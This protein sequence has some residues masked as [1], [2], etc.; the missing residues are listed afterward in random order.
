MDRFIRFEYSDK[1]FKLIDDYKNRQVVSLDLALKPVLSSVNNLEYY[2]KKAK[3]NCHYPS[4]HNLSKDE[5]AAVY[6]YTDDCGDQSLHNV[7]NQTLQTK[8]KKKLKPWFNFLQLFNTALEKL[9][10]VK[11]TIWR[12][13]PIDTVEKLEEN[14]ELVLCCV[15][16]SSLS[17]DI[18]KYFLTNNPILCSIE[19]LNGKDIHD[20]TSTTS[21]Q[22]VLLLPGTCLRVKSKEQNNKRDKVII[23]FEEISQVDEDKSIGNDVEM[24]DNSQL[25]NKQDT[26]I[27]HQQTKPTAL[28]NEMNYESSSKKKKSNE[29]ETK[30]VIT[31]VNGH[32]YKLKY[33]NGMKQDYGKYYNVD[34]KKFEGEDAEDKATGEGICTYPNGSRYIGTFKRGN[35]NGHGILYNTDGTVQAGIW[36]NDE[37]NNLDLKTISNS[38]LY[39]WKNGNGEERHYYVYDDNNGNK[40]IGNIVDG[41]A[42]GLGIRIWS[43][44]SRYEGNFKD[45]KKHGYGIYYYTDRDIYKGQWANDEIN[46]EGKLTW[47]SGTHYQGK[48]VDG[49][50]HGE[51]T[52][53]FADGQKQVGKWEKDKFGT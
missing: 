40:Y 22:E 27:D 26:D 31:F 38:H 24:V 25:T 21:D 50:R 32:R 51:G 6:L 11:Q 46:G 20:Y 1:D 28:T 49:K 43:D 9:P 37:P 23:C 16:S 19:P 13:L 41:K 42:Q 5:S 15:T 34:G 2:I 33:R 14:D 30:A 47:S 3:E 44:N 48:F 53:I 10:N 8:D 35:R 4:K 45:N 36:A 17:I 52:L 39:K 7:L 12:G 29:N 18:M